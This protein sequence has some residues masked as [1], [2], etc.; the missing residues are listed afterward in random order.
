MSAIRIGVLAEDRTD[1]ATLGVLIR[2]I[3]EQAGGNTVKISRYFTGGCSHLRRKAKTGM[4]GFAEEG[5]SAVV[6]LHD[7]DRNPHNGE[8]NDES[9]LRGKLKTIP[10]PSGVELLVCIPVEE[11]EAWFWSDPG[12]VRE[13]GRDKGQAHA[14]PHLLKKPKEALIKLS[15]GD[16]RKA[17]Y[18]TNDNARLAE[19]LD[20]DLCEKRCPS[21]RELRAFISDVVRPAR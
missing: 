16:N 1:C 10:V 4:A 17:R 12:V 9:V 13:V 21:F 20:L 6:L 3:V 14:S 5:C 7:L 8:L 18:S 2:R 19:K 11:I 15:V